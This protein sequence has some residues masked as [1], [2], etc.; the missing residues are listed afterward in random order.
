[1]RKLAAHSVVLFLISLI[2]LSGCQV[3]QSNKDVSP[4]KKNV[5]LILVDDLRPQLGVY[6]NTEMKTP[7]MDRLASQG[8]TFN[9]AYCNVPVCGASRASMLTGKRPT[10]DRFLTYYSSI[11]KEMPDVPTI[12]KHLKHH[13]YTTVSN[14]KI[15]HLKQDA[16]GSWNEEWYPYDADSL[17]WRDYITDVNIIL[18]SNNEHGYAY[19]SPDVDDDAYYDGKTTTKSIQDLRKFKESGD[20]FFLAVGLVKPHLPFNAPKKYWDLY[21]ESEINL[22]DNPMYPSSAPKIANHNWGELRYYKDIPKKGPVP[23]ELAKKLIHGYYASTSYIDAQIGRIMDAL[24]ELELR[25]DTVVVLVGDHGWSLGEHGLWAKHSNFEKALR[26]PLIISSTK[27]KNNTISQSVVELVDLY[28][29]ICALSNNP[30]PEHTDGKSLLA[31]LKDPN[32]IYRNSAMVRWK[33]GE[34]LIAD[35]YFYTEWHNNNGVFAKMLYDHKTDPGENT[36]LAADN[37]HFKLV[38]SL[39]IILNKNLKNYSE[40]ELKSN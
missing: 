4:V 7:H 14:N 11:K 30:I 19:E 27:G 34:T 28:P 38:D 40:K 31:E 23:D 17:G 6:G 26:V 8:V 3:K 32:K 36:N 22:A 25:D 9:R 24:E 2:S 29:T 35:N 1:M 15:A 13:G 37:T 16:P 10:K 21:K 39:S 33:K 12:A 20:P 5:V 18:E